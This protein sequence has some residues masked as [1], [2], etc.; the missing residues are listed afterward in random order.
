MKRKLISKQ[1]LFVDEYL[2]G[3]NITKAEIEDSYS[4][5]TAKS[6]CIENLTLNLLLKPE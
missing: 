2:T 6:I 1:K 5:K 4:L 3:G